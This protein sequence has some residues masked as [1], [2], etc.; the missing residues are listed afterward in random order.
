MRLDLAVTL[1]GDD[2][3]EVS[4]DLAAISEDDTRRAIELVGIEPLQDLARGKWNGLG[5]RALV[6]VALTNEIPDVELDFDRL[7]LDFGEDLSEFLPDL[8]LD[9]EAELPMEEA[10]R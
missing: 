10:E 5:A 7:D 9:L 4:V 8:D 6:F 2:V 1:P 3:R